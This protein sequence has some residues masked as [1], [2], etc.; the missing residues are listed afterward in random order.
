[1][2]VMNYF[3]V[4]TDGLSEAQVYNTDI[5]QGV[6]LMCTPDNEK[7]FEERELITSSVKLD[8]L[9][10]IAKTLKADCRASVNSKH[11]TTEGWIARVI[12]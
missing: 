10:E 12:R 2:K 7:Y 3:T 8:D 1:M 11:I 6:V 5:T 9:H 4:V